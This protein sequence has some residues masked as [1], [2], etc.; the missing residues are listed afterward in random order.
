MYGIGFMSFNHNIVDFDLAGNNYLNLD[1]RSTQFFV[2]DISSLEFKICS[3]FLIIEL[4]LYSKRIP[5]N[6]HF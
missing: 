4:S 2:V 5:G 6:Y 3:P 1:G